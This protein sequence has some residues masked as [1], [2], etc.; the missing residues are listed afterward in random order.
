MM[1]DHNPSA[2]R[3]ILLLSATIISLIA[4][5]FWLAPDRFLSV[6]PT[7]FASGNIVPGAILFAVA[8]IIYLVALQPDLRGMQQAGIQATTLIAIQTTT[9]TGLLLLRGATVSNG[10]EAGFALSGIITLL[11][12]IALHFI[13]RA[14]NKA[15]TSS[16]EISSGSLDPALE[17][18]NEAGG[19]KEQISILNRR[20]E[21]EKHRSTRL[22]YLNELSRQLEAEL[23]PEVAAQLAVNTLEQVMDCSLVTLLMHEPEHRQ[24]LV[25]TSAG[26]LSNNLP[27]GYRQDQNKG[28]L[29]RTARIK[30]TQVVNDTRAD[31]DFLDLH[32]GQLL[33]LISVPI[34]QHSEVKSVLEIGSE[35]PDAFTPADVTIA[36]DVTTELAIAWQR[37][38]YHQRLREL[39]RLQVGDY[40]AAYKED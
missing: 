21:A 22:T 32:N 39:I 33:S 19:L 27:P 20:I 28:V 24:Y 30:K 40:H 16:L 34:L 36:E 31:P 26:A 35:H 38:S 14:E 5:G 4:Q 17:P 6:L 37:Y 8:L 23:E 12:A 2:T 3:T 18:A 25:L 13:T 10:G 1:K 15:P 11:T 9:A 7:V 29:G